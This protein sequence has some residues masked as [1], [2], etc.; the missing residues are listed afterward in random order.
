MRG[1]ETLLSLVAACLSLL[2]YFLVNF[3]GTF[4]ANKLR[5]TV[6]ASSF[7]GDGTSINRVLTQL[8]CFLLYSREPSFFA[9]GTTASKPASEDGRL[10]ATNTSP[11]QAPAAQSPPAEAATCPLGFDKK[12]DAKQP[13]G[14]GASS[15]TTTTTT[16]GCPVEKEENAEAVASSATATDGG[17]AACPVKGSEGQISK[18]L[19]PHKYNVY[20]QRVGGSAAGPGPV[21]GGGA[22]DPSNNMPS[23]PN[24]QPAPGQRKDLSTERVRSSIPKGGEENTWTYPSP[25]MFW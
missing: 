19:H 6:L 2:D 11:A 10:E 7:Q 5:S 21:G 24:Q 22:M 12:K 17:A 13:E 9:M 14:S 18:Y 15:T 3:A 20:S 1:N 8:H 16:R 23:N 25:Q 4:S